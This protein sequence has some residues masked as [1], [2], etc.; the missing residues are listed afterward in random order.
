MR[1]YGVWL[2][3]RSGFDG[4]RLVGASVL[5]RWILFAGLR[6]WILAPATVCLICRWSRDRTDLK[7]RPT[8]T[9]LSASRSFL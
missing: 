1:D 7:I 2:L 6:E 8:A 9:E 4:C 5:T 3:Y